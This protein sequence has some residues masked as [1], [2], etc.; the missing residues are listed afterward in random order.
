MWNCWSAYATASE[1][2]TVQAAL[3]AAARQR[4]EEADVRYNSGFLTYDSWEIIVTDCVSQGREAIQSRFTAA[5]AQA[6]WENALENT[7]GM[8]MW[9]KMFMA[10]TLLAALGEGFG[11]GVPRAM[12]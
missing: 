9:R 1:N 7:G 2:A 5:T 6:V 11:F 10:G 4:N 8:I 3:L 12:S